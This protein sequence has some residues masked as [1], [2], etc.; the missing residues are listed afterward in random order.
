MDPFLDALTQAFVTLV[1]RFIYVLS[2]P[3]LPGQRI[4][5]VYLLTSIGFAYWVYLRQANGKPAQERSF[6]RFLL[7]KHVWS[8][9]SA[10]LDLRYFFFN[11][12][13]GK[14]LS[15]ALIAAT[16]NYTFQWASGGLNLLEAAKAAPETSLSRFALSFAYMFVVIGCV[17][18]VSYVLHYLQHKVPFLWEFHKVHHSLEVMH[19]ISNYREHPI[20]NVAYALGTG[21]AYGL[22]MGSA[23]SLFGYLPSMPELLGVPLL[24]FAFNI[25]G[26][27]LRHSHVWLRWP[28]RWAMVFPSPAHHHVHHSCHPD[29]IDK[30]FAFMFPLWDVLFRTYHL[31][32]T[33]KDVKFGISETYES[34]FNSCLQLYFVPFR[35]AYSLVRRSL[36]RKQAR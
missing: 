26:Y 30:N 34:E 20:D 25:L 2:Y 6:L 28:G 19:P 1:S 15:F 32:D 21:A 4:F 11:Q 13:F 22:T 12:I 18:F 10:W 3:I 24:M 7:P 16:L 17:D 8:H 36:R 29:H 33:D 14:M 27:N 35:N 23:H 9:P 5:L 31:P